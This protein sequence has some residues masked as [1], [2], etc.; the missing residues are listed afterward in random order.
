MNKLVDFY[1]TMGDPQRLNILQ[2][3]S[4]REMSV[5]EI[6]CQL[7]LSQPAV[8]HHLK[9]L[10]QAG[11]VAC[12]KQGKLV[13]YSLSEERTEEIRQLVSA[14][15]ESLSLSARGPNKPSALR[16]NQNFCELIGFKKSICEKED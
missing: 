4:G 11:L 5:C 1:K 15:L 16:E 6:M 13:F 2:M 12:G 9:I 10:R 8:S 3:L 7:E 14:H